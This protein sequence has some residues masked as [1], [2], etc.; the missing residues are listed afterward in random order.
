MKQ[1]LYMET[2]IPSYY[3]ALPSRDIIILAHQEI[4]RQWWR[5][6]KNNYNI[7]VSEL[8]IE[9]ALQGDSFASKRRLNV[10]N[11]FK[12]LSIN[13]E[14]EELGLYYIKKIPILKHAYRDA[15][16]LAIA[17]LNKMDYLLTWNCTHLNQAHLKGMIRKINNAQGVFTPVIC[18]PEELMGGK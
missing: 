8:V 5:E 16:H 6:D 13:K 4:T 12:I 3:T 15:I 14:S 18:T 17:S 1:T 2:T 9:E 10:I 11:K 7:H